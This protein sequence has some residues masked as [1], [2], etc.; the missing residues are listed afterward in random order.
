V[1]QGAGGDISKA[2][3][4]GV[5]ITCLIFVVSMYLPVI[6]SFVAMLIP[7]P[8]LFFRSK[9][10][11]MPGIIIPVLTIFI[12]IITTGSLSFNVIFFFELLLLGFVLSEL[13][14]LNLSVE[15]TIIYTCVVVLLSGLILLFF[16][17]N[18]SNLGL[19]ALISEYVA[20]NLELTMELYKKM[21]M[22]EENLRLISDSLEQ[23]QFV[24]VGI[25]PALAIASSLIVV[26]TN[27]LIIKPILKSKNLFYPEFGRLNQWKAPEFLVWFAIACGILLLMPNQLVKLI[28]LNGIL[29][30]MVVYFFQGI[31]VVSFFFEAKRFPRMLRILFYGIIFLQQLILLLVIGL[32]FFDIWLDFRKHGKAPPVQYS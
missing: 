6:G 9:L 20:K 4:T 16:L 13:F 23:I 24:L 15:K 30:M 17:S 27:L 29:V 32:G 31:A 18:I 19:I 14:E 21:G 8:T 10:G 11:R 2:I 26:W 3:I 1:S 12:L 25:I 5:A 22:P 7:L 28:G